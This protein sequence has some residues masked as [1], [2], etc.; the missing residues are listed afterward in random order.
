MVVQFFEKSFIKDL[1]GFVKDFPQGDDEVRRFMHSRANE[2]K[3]I[4]YFFKMLRYS[5]DQKNE[6]SPKLAQVIREGT[7]EQKC[8]AGVL[9]KDT[10]KTNFIGLFELELYLRARYGGQLKNNNKFESIRPSI[11]L[12]VE[13]LDKQFGHEYYW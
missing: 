7:L 5:E 12:F 3:K 13:S 10:L 6:M 1:D 2:L 8:G 11:E 9:H 4:R